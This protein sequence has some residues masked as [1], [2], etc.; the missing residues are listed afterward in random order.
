MG[1]IIYFFDKC[2]RFLSFCTADI[3][4]GEGWLWIATVAAPVPAARTTIVLCD[5]REERAATVVLWGERGRLLG[6]NAGLF[7][8]GGL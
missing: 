8:A 1:R 6:E 5:L 2:K 3:G 7:A 4:K